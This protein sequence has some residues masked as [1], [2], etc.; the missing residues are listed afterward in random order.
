MK[1]IMQLML[2][3]TVSRVIVNED[4]IYANFTQQK[5]PHSNKRALKKCLFN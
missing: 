2:N 3:M 1:K 5:M 4:E